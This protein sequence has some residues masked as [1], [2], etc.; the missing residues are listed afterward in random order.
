MKKTF[1]CVI[2]FSALIALYANA[3]TDFDQAGTQGVYLD[4]VVYCNDFFFWVT[5][6]G[7]KIYELNGF[8]YGCG[9]DNRIAFGTVHVAGGYAYVAFEIQSPEHDYGS[10]CLNNYAINLSTKSGSGPWLYI[11][12]SAGS[13]TSFGGTSTYNMSFGNY[14]TSTD[15]VSSDRTGK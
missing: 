2:L 1:F 11:Y 14:P 15:A 12:E 5:E 4:D 8:E 6:V 13:L 7:T 3:P 9:Y 10:L